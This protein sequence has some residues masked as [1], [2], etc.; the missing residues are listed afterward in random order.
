MRLAVHERA[1]R[2]RAPL[3]TA[4]GTLERRDVLLV[5]VTDGEGVTG[6]GEAA[7]LEPYDGVGL[8]TARAALEAYGLILA[9]SDGM[10]PGD[11]LDA[12]REAADLPQALAGL[13][14]AL[15]DLRG[16]REGR[17]VAAMLASEPA[18]RVPVNA[19]IGALDRAGASAEAADAARRGFRCVKVK[20]GVGDDAGRVAAVRAA[21][22][23]EVDLRLD[24]NGAWSPGEAIAA[25]GA[26]APAGLELVEEPVHGLDGLREVREGAAVRVAMDESGARPGALMSGAADAVCLKLSRSG[27]ISS[28]LADAVAVRA[29]GAEVYLASTFEGPLG[30]AAALH[31]AAALAPTPA[32]GLATVG[33]FADVTDPFPPHEGTIAVPTGPGL[34]VD[35]GW[36]GPP[37][38]AGG[39]PSADQLE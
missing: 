10:L 30:V 17:P 19:T 9:G 36:G 32:C 5:S 33:L 27:G 3:A 37:P 35:P 25:L 16:R 18:A 29:T 2:F 11:R 15:W 31:A 13:D 23:P 6:W 1:Y 14:L 24:A 22:G 20:V 38:K 8:S 21:L 34:G 4:H 7:P 12:C 39:R 26:L 28:L